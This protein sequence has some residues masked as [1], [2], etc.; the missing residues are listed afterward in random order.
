[1]TGIIETVVEEAKILFGY[2]E[3]EAKAL[4]VVMQPAITL[5]IKELGTNGMAIA[6]GVLAAAISGT[7]WGVIIATF[8]PLAEAD[9]IKV[10]EDVASLGLNL[11]KANLIAKGIVAAAPAPVSAEIAPTPAA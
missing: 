4:A 9:G 5:A 11:A 6:E 3:D 8:L 7:S 10:T 2:A 1:M